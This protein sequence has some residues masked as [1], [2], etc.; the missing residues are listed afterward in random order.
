MRIIHFT[1]G[2][3]NMYCGSCFRDNAL[4][5]ALKSL[6]H[7]VLLQPVYTPTRTDEDN[8][9]SSEVLF[10]GISIYLQQNYGLFRK[11][12]RFLDRLFD[13]RPALKLA[14]R[15][16]IPTSPKMLGELTVSMLQGETGVLA[17][18]FDKLAEWLKRE[19]PPDVI[20]IS[21]SLL[22]AL[23]SS[24]RKVW[25]R[26]IC[27]TIQGEDLFLDGLEEPYRSESLRLIRESARHV[28]LF[29]AVSDYC[30]AVMP[31]YLGLSPDRVQVVPI[32][33]DFQG[34]EPRLSKGAS[35]RI[36]Y[37][38][39][40]A[41]EKG[42]HNLCEAYRLLREDK[43][44]PASRLE[45]AGYLGPEHR[46][47]IADIESRMRAWGL[48]DQFHYHG[49]L[50]RQQKID[51]LRSLDVLSVPSVYREPKGL[52]LLEA[53]A[54]GV[55]VVQPRHGAY[56]EIIARTGGGIT[57]EPDNPAS[58]AEGLLKLWKD[59]DLRN[60]AGRQAYEGVRR[61]YSSRQMAER[62]IDVYSSVTAPT[63]SR[64]TAR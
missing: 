14:A 31:A 36:G 47:Y 49:V 61:H 48:A 18:E 13:S 63:A 20:N 3:A 29:I 51:F 9:S 23:A 19:P 34:Y 39:R 58:L 16:S 64:G 7:D 2:A 24:I 54:C 59:E 60:S 56:P 12:P 28:D 30:A 5:A 21:Y 6:G 10:G 25:D 1:A 45:V 4:A 33:I 8:V 53:M 40:V 55:P 42:L 62:L 43:S 38:A 44:L 35:F 52:F 41:P 46:A 37:F 22:I 32:G 26:P 11:A 50:D 17:R 27:C 57:V 15:S